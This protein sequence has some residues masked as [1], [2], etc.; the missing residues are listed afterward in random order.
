MKS[1]G[2]GASALIQLVLLVAFP[3][4]VARNAVWI[5]WWRGGRGRR[6][7][8]MVAC[9]SSV[10]G[11]GLALLGCAGWS[12]WFRVLI[13]LVF[14]VVV[15][16]ALCLLSLWE[17]V[18]RDVEECWGHSCST[19]ELGRWRIP[20]RRGM[21]WWSWFNG[22]GWNREW[23]AE[24]STGAKAIECDLE[25]EC[26]HCMCVC[27]VCMRCW[28]VLEQQVVV[29]NNDAY[30]SWREIGMNLA[31]PVMFMECLWMLLFPRF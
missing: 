29:L 28:D 5:G 12:I 18:F 17:G 11:M 22:G 30:V 20:Y 8:I 21:W 3:W 1:T 24:Q 13:L 19:V 25:Y 10:R 15:S 31:L 16:E 27:N 26:D 2:A 6:V 14:C 9:T 7:R 23:E 4:Y